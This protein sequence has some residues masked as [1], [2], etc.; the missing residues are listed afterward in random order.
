MQLEVLAREDQGVRERQRLGLL[1]P[2]RRRRRLRGGRN[3]SNGGGSRAGG[4]QKWPWAFGLPRPYKGRGGRA[5]PPRGDNP[6]F[7]PPHP[8]PFSP[9]GGGGGGGRL[10]WFLGGSRF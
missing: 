4:R 1:R 9:R 10:G 2:P 5:L 7:G 8:R 3:L 6:C